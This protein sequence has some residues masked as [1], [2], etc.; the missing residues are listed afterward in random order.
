MRSIWTVL[1]SCWRIDSRNASPEPHPGV[2][3]GHFEVMLRPCGLILS[4]L[5]F[6]IELVSEN[7]PWKRSPQWPRSSHVH[8]HRSE[9]LLLPGTDIAAVWA[10]SPVACEVPG[11]ASRGSEEGSAA[12]PLPKPFAWA[13]VS[14]LSYL[15]TY[16]S[17]Y[18]FIYLSIYPSILAILFIFNKKQVMAQMMWPRSSWRSWNWPP[19]SEA[20]SSPGLQPSPDAAAAKTAVKLLASRDL[21]T[22]VPGLGQLP[23]NRCLLQR[24]R[25]LTFQGARA[26]LE[27]VIQPQDRTANQVAQLVC[28]GGNRR[29]SLSNWPHVLAL[30]PFSMSGKEIG[31]RHRRLEEA[32][33]SP[34]GGD[35]WPLPSTEGFAQR[36]I[37]PG[38]PLRQQRQGFMK[39]N[40]GLALLQK[41]FP[42]CLHEC[43][44]SAGR[45]YVLEL[46][47]LLVL[48]Q[49]HAVT[50]AP[51][52]ID[53]ELWP[54][55][56][57]QC[58]LHRATHRPGAQHPPSA[59]R[60]AVVQ[61]TAAAD[62]WAALLEP[63]ARCPHAVVQLHT[64]VPPCWSD[65]LW[66]CWMNAL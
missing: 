39:K 48:P 42:P 50:P 37:H 55:Q 60:L 12:H 46:R 53:T 7:W 24:L 40:V 49:P 61:N 65:H 17:T 20:A 56:S 41:S 9:T 26:K 44:V 63:P 28:V 13:T 43:S 16:L 15:G 2:K 31:S 5:I 14:H 51:R 58:Q 45:A 35:S 4:H 18:V 57:F 6:W 34:D 23:L 30:P 64:N 62:G 19:H 21:P 22:S 54:M 52:P 59:G 10:L 27:E 1:G 47:G 8:P 29:K 32:G 3:F 11:N 36:W 66:L 38:S 33:R 25:E